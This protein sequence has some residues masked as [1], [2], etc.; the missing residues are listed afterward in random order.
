MTLIELATLGVLVLVTVLGTWRLMRSQRRREIAAGKDPRSGSFSSAA[1]STT[2]ALK[3]DPLVSL[4]ATIYLPVGDGLYP[5][6]TSASKSRAWKNA[7]LNWLERGA[8]LNMIVTVPNSDAR[9]LWLPLEQAHPQLFGYYELDRSKASPEIA[10]EIA[11]LDTYHPIIIVCDQGPA[12]P[13]AMWIEQYHPLDSPFAYAV[14]YVA[15]ADAA[16][17]RRFGSF[18]ALYRKILVGAHVRRG[19]DPAVAEAA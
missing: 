4:G 15:P 16:R 13:G 17:D 5:E 18:Q 11:R 2:L 9:A 14:D 3:I 1:A 6:R 8:T 10:R 12:S 19:I 7:L